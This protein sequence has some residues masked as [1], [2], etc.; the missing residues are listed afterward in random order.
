MHLWSIISLLLVSEVSLTHMDF[1]EFL[2]YQTQ[3]EQVT[4]VLPYVYFSLGA[5]VGASVEST[6]NIKNKCAGDI[7]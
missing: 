6:G 2:V 4:E 5:I 1:N 7:T 3:D